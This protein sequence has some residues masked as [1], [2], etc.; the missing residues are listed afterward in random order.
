MSDR[1]SPF[2]CPHDS[3]ISSNWKSRFA[4]TA[5]IAY[6]DRRQY[7]VTVAEDISYFWMYMACGNKG[8]MSKNHHYCNNSVEF[9]RTD[10]FSRLKNWQAQ[11]FRFKSKKSG[12][13]KSKVFSCNVI[14]KSFLTKKTNLYFSR[15]ITIRVV[16]LLNFALEVL[17]FAVFLK[18]FDALISNRYLFSFIKSEEIL[19]SARHFPSEMYLQNECQNL[20]IHFSWNV[21]TYF[22]YDYHCAQ[23]R[24][25]VY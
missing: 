18:Q 7:W 12:Y 14:L 16:L 11:L 25:F 4:A 10:S 23:G 22:Y 6:D 2:R 15:H 1:R 3:F 20:N 21:C 13:Y 24:N 19:W 5:K 8:N 17:L 9:N